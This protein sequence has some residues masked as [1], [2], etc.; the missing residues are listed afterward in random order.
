M[1]Q[2]ASG[3]RV[4]QCTYIGQMKRKNQRDD[5]SGH[6]VDIRPSAHFLRSSRK[7]HAL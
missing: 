1:K 2:F 7:T 3:K 6:F 5:E 4:G